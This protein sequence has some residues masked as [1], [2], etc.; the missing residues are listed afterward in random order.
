LADT[1]AQIYAEFRPRYPENLLEELRFRTIGDHGELLIDWGCGTGEVT[2]PLSLYFDSVRAVDVG[3]DRISIAEENAQKKG[4]ENVEWHIG[5]AEDLEIATESCDL[6]TCASAFHWMDRELLSERAFRGLRN[7]GSLAIAG[8]GG[9]DI[10]SGSKDWHEVAR[11]C[12]VKYLESPSSEGKPASDT[13]NTNPAK[14]RWH[15][16]YLASAGFEVEHLQLPTEFSWPVD[17]VA[18]YLYSITGGIPWTLGDKRADFEREFSEAL[19]RLNPSGM[20]HETIDF[21]LLIASK[22]G[23]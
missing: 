18:G 9:D 12:L 15:A 3:A 17:K 11:A 23:K 5:R 19:T 8:G 21:F 14:K 7:G 6:I 20:V 1:N 4:V 16:D 22:P 13:S 2:L 10:W